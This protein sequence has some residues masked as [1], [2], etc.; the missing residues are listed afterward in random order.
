MNIRETVTIRSPNGKDEECAKF[1]IDEVARPYVFRKTTNYNEK[2]TYSAWV[3]SEIES[4]LSIQGKEIPVT[5]NWKRQK[6]VFTASGSSLKIHFNKAGIYYIYKSQLETGDVAT[7]WAPSPEDIEESLKATNARFELVVNKETL[8]TEINALADTF[9][10]T[11]NGFVVNA[12]NL[13]ITEDGT[14]TALN[15]EFKGRIDA[16]KGTIAGFD[17]NSYSLSKLDE[18]GYGIVVA[19][20]GIQT[21]SEYGMVEHKSYYSEYTNWNSGRNASHVIISASGLGVYEV[22][23][24]EGYSIQTDVSFYIDD[25]IQGR[26]DSYGLVSHRYNDG[27]YLI[28]W[29]GEMYPKSVYSEGYIATGTRMYVPNNKSIRGMKYEYGEFPYHDTSLAYDGSV[30]M[31][32]VST[33]DRVVLGNSDNPAATEIRSPGTI[34]FK[35]NGT[36]EDDDN[37]YAMRFSRLNFGT[38]DNPTY[39]GCLQPRLDN[40]TVIGSSNYR[41]RNVYS[42]N[43]VSTTSDR[44][45]KRNINPISDKYIELFDLLKPVTYVLNEGERIHTGFIS[46]DVEEAM[47][48]IGMSSMEFGGF[49]KDIISDDEGVPILDEY[50]KEKTYYSLRYKEFIAINTTKIK[51]L[52]R[53]IIELE[54]KISYGN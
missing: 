38:T 51:Q 52:E 39:Y 35:C 19:T 3:M 33:N 2:Y 27:E 44:N 15:G 46:Q 8:K 41:F 11:G 26:V 50:G 48:S 1:T 23:D 31:I 37:R 30:A 49:C 6:I 10:F 21:I 34:W 18:D 28:Q 36:T 7:D 24:N 53:K 5:T 40:Y 14:I 16:E 29:T 32:Y 9:T 45:L 47:N 20:D 4:T 22:T 42:T 13:T 17:I 12:K 43:G 25:E 54:R